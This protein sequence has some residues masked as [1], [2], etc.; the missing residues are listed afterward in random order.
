M[1]F[2]NPR[3]LYLNRAAAAGVV[4]TT[5]STPTTGFPAINAADWRPF[6]KWADTGLNSYWI[7]FNAGS[8]V[9]ASAAAL[10]AHN[11][12]TA[13]WRYI[14]EGSNNDAAWTEIVAYTTPP[15]DKTLA[16]FF[17]QV[18]F[19]YYR[20]TIDNNGGAAFDLEIGIAFIG[21]YLDMENPPE[22]PADPDKQRLHSSKQ[23]GESG[24]LLGIAEYWIER[25]QDWTFLY[26]SQSWVSN[27]W[28]PYWDTYHNQP[29]ISVWNYLTNT[30]EAYLMRFDMD[31][32]TV[33]YDS[34]HRSLTLKMNGVKET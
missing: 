17:N 32:M 9:T 4:I 16:D 20:L 12:D 28:L 26:L 21:E 23:Q 13:G 5:L 15:D 2:A 33:P 11:A 30:D 25:I 1:A 27:T 6:F 31:E 3:F 29:F 19:Q 22:M 10:V 7:K 24:N 14:W 34:I 18:T 8:Q